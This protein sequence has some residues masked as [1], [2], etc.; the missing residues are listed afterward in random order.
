M[1]LLLTYKSTYGG[2]LGC[3]VKN[4]KEK[5]VTKRKEKGERHREERETGRMKRK[6]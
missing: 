1:R 3:I 5:I 2:T 4:Y 6:K